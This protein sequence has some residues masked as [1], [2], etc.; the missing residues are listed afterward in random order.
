MLT[1]MKR[2]VFNLGF[3]KNLAISL[4]RCLESH[5]PG[6]RPTATD[7][8]PWQAY[9][10]THPARRADLALIAHNS[11][12]A[13]RASLPGC[14]SEAR[15]AASYVRDYR[16]PPDD[17]QLLFFSVETSGFIHCMAKDFMKRLL[18]SSNVAYIQTLQSIS[19]LQSTR[20]HSISVPREFLTLPY[21]AGPLQQ[22]PPRLKSNGDICQV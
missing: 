9:D 11:G 1:H 7:A 16:P 13:D 8:D 4:D 6:V 21:T 2:R 3:L 12:A 17:V 18:A 15:Y 14:A 22:V 10:P 5:F 19:T 20:A